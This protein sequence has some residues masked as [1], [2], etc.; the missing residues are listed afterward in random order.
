[1]A[2]SKNLRA[3]TGRQT[4]AGAA[5][6]TVL[7]EL[8][9]AAAAAS[10]AVAAGTQFT[11]SDWYVTTA[12]ITTEFRLQKTDDG[13]NWFDLAILLVPSAGTIGLELKTAL[14]LSG[15]ANAAF[16][17]RATTP[18]GASAVSTTLRGYSS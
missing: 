5:E 10:V 16:R 15:G 17:V 1:M 7:L 18:P 3:I 11:I 8:D 14:R 13:V 6:E 4:T 2:G 9:G 12:A